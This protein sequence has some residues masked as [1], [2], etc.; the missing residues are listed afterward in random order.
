MYIKIIVIGA[1]VSYACVKQ[2]KD[3]ERPYFYRVITID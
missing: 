2:D 1:Y 3:N